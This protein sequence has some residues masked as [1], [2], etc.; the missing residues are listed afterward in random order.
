MRYLILLARTAPL[1]CLSAASN[2]QIGFDGVAPVRVGMTRGQAEQALHA[3][4][5]FEFL[6]DHGPNGCGQADVKVGGGVVGYMIEKGRITRAD[7]YDKAAKTTL[8]TV[9]GIGLGS[10]I[11][12]IRRA[13]GRRVRSHPNAY[14]DANPDFEIKS[15]DGKAAIVFETEHGHVARIHAGRLPAAEYIE[16]CA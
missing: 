1:L 8:K 7:V 9:T 3:K 16:G 15:A 11:G 14:D 6:N 13:Y 5:S 2:P 10:S 4:L 12:D